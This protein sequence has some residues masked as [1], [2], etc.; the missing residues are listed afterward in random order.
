MFHAF[1]D[2]AKG[3]AEMATTQDFKI[4]AFQ[5]KL[6][7]LSKQGT[8][9]RFYS[10]YD[11][12]YRRDI[13]MEAYRQCRANK[14][15]AGVDGVTFADIGQQGLDNWIE[16]IAQMLHNREY[17]PQPVMRVYIQKPDGGLRPLGIPTIRDRVVQTACKIVIEPI[18][19]AH[20][21]D[22][23]Y[24]Y[25]PKRGAAD[26]IRQIE[27][28]IKQGYVHVYDADLKGYFDNIP[29]DRL[30]DKIARRIS[31]KSI[32]ALIRKFLRAP[33]AETN[34][35]GK[36]TITE[37]RKGTPQGGV[38]SPLFANIYLNDF[39]ELINTKTPCRLISY[40]DDFV[41]LHKEPFTEEQL[42]WFKGKLEIEGLRLNEA[43]R[44]MS[45]K[46]RHGFHLI[47]VQKQSFMVI[48]DARD[49]T[50]T[51][52]HGLHFIFEGF[53]SGHAP[54]PLSAVV[55]NGRRFLGFINPGGGRQRLRGWHFPFKPFRVFNK[56]L[57]Q[58]IRTIFNDQVRH[59]VMDLFRR[60]QGDP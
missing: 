13:L 39:S 2:L 47:R 22:G 53:R 50:A 34:T 12:V 29:H 21:N 28:S 49:G 55:I 27:R 37:S 51:V 30:M 19:E 54:P 23:S 44:N 46:M 58:Y 24:G 26:A 8:D 4:R 52:G 14:G 10:L 38:A 11:K 15:A 9:Y 20:F 48:R 57:L 40:A 36:I 41:I 59:A 3:I 25:R 5:R 60:H 18:F 45:M 7:M 33:V 31:D 56:S 32:L 17:V 43:K 16:Q 1:G 6:Y 35:N 42:A